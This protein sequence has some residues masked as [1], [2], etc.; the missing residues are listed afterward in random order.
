M[1]NY[2]NIYSTGQFPI[3]VKFS[4]SMVTVFMAMT[5]GLGMPIMFPMGAII[6]VN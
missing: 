3:H 4:E 6:L 1:Q 5:Y 2:K